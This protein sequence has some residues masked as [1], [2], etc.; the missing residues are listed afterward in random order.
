VLYGMSAFRLAREFGVPRA[1]AKRFIERYFARY[2]GIHEYIE[3]TL[4][5]GR[6]HGYVTTLFGR[7]RTIPDLR[8]GQ[9][10]VQQAA[11]RVAINTPVQGTAADII[12]QAMVAIAAELAARGLGARMVLQVHDELMF[13]VPEAEVDEVRALV[14]ERMEGVASL[15]VPLVVDVGAGTTWNEAHG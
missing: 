15:R 3:R 1:E 13:E 7:R 5:H 8:A 12:K 6:E 9:K 2:P 11:E 4:E 10:N 14:R